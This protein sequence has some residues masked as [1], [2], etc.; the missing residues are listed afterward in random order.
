MT[1]D[2]S[3]ATT[4]SEAD[5]GEWVTRNVAVREGGISLQTTTAIRESEL[6]AS[7]V[8]HAVDPDGVLYTVR[9]SGAV[10]RYDPGPDR[11]ERLLGRTDAGLREPCAICAG[12]R[13]VFV[14]DAVDGTVTAVSTRLKR[15]IGTLRSAVTDPVELAA[16]G[17]TIYALDGVGRVVP[18]GTGEREETGDEDV[19]DPGIGWW[20]T[21][22]VD[23]AVVGDVVFVL[24]DDDGDRAVRAF[25]GMD[26][27]TDDPL[28]LSGAAFE[29]AGERF[30][31]T[32]LAAPTDTLAVA[33]TFRDRDGHG[34]FEWNHDEDAF[35]RRF[36]FDERPLELVGQSSDAGD[37][38]VFYAVVGEDRTCHAL[39]E[40]AE[41]AGHADRDRHVGTAV[42]RYDSGTQ[43]TEWHRIELGIARSSPSTQVRLR[44][45]AADEPVHLDS[46]TDRLDWLTAPTAATLREAGVTSVWELATADP[47][48]IASVDDDVTDTAVRDWQR[49][50][51]AELDTRAET[52]WTTADVI[53]PVD[54]LVDDAE[55][56]YLY[57]AV[58]LVGTPESSPLVDSVRAFCP[59]QSYLRYLP[60][61]Y[62]EDEQ[63]AAFLERFLSV[64]ETSFVDVQETIESLPRYF[65]PYGVPSESL[66]WLEEWLAV[67]A[68]PDWPETAR[69]ELLARAPELYKKRGTK[70]GL[71][72]TLELYLRHADPDG[73]TGEAPDAPDG[74]TA[75]ADASP[76]EASTATADGG[77]SPSDHRLFFLEYGDLDCIEDDA[78]HAA[79]A[80]L[81][82]GER[83]F[84]LFC[85]PLESDDQRRT[86]RE[87]VDSE[88]PAHVDGTVVAIEEEWTLGGDSFLGINSRLDARKFTM[89]DATLGEDTVLAPGESTR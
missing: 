21:D 49:A 10:Y 31:P 35:E 19:V 36:A 6:A 27:L 85:G 22:P 51:R 20:L 7:V 71:R 41:H 16:G 75:G 66:P 18:V 52:E 17:G 24:D 86:V 34:L 47:D 38:R 82:S 76:P 5:W 14:A 58:E 3:Y 72:A 73:P 1:V 59:R 29:A 56:R 81:L 74:T 54:V 57:V 55:G 46:S 84:A 67:D 65:D 70:A 69:R 26:E 61:L 87:I 83:S 45:H 43:G 78:A 30:V 50:A 68:D 11:H 44:Y 23:L 64:F 63:S 62:R 89:S 79:Y 33:G 9:S 80:S 37:G 60:E 77:D 8:D 40:L 4:T 13:R 42:R 25:R 88:R 48:R 53:D 12:D 15:T 39:R 28:P 2:F 32:C